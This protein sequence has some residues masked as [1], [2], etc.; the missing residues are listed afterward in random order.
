MRSG[1]LGRVLKLKSWELLS[2]VHTPQCTAPQR[3]CPRRASVQLC[4]DCV[5]PTGSMHGTL[6]VERCLTQLEL[7]TWSRVKSDL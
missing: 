7:D 5:E 3:Q 4:D 1:L 6:E 2:A